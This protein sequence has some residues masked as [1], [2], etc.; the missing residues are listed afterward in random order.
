[1]ERIQI[2][3]S[4]ELFLTYPICQQCDMLWEQAE[5][6]YINVEEGQMIHLYVIQGFF[7]EVLFRKGGQMIDL[8]KA[9]EAASAIEKYWQEV[10]IE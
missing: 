6:L 5:L 4:P 2:K 10:N 3:M 1:M 7:V 9:Y 8:I